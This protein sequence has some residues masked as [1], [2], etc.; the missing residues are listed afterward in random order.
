MRVGWA[1]LVEA[2]NDEAYYYLYNV[3]PDLSFIDHPP[4]T[5]WVMQAGLFLRGGLVDPLSLRLGFL[6]LFAGS[7]WAIFRVTARWYGEWAGFH[8]A[9][10]LNL[11][12]YYT[13]AAGAF[14]LP[15]GPFLFF[16]LLTIGALADALVAQTG[17]S[18]RQWCW[19]GLAWSGMLLSKYHAI[20]MPAG[21]LLYIALTPGTRRLLRTP[22]PYLA[23]AIGLLAFTPV[24]IW[25]VR[26]DWA[27]FAFQGGRALKWRFE[28]QG[29]IV[30]LL[31]TALMLSPWVWWG[32]VR[33][34]ADR[35]RGKRENIDR[36][37]LCLALV[38]MVFFLVLS[39]GR[40]VLAHWPLVGFIPLFCYI[41]QR[42]A[43]LAEAMP[44]RM[45]WNVG[46]MAGVLLLLA[47]A[48][49][50]QAKFGLAPL[51]SGDPCRQFSG[52]T[53]VADELQSRGLLGAETAFLFTSN[54]DDSGQ[55]AFAVRAVKPVLCYNSGDA[56][57]FAIWS[58]P[59]DWLGQDGLLVSLD[60]NQ[61]EPV[62]Y[63]R[64]FKKIEL[65]AAFPM[66]RGGR[67]FRSVRVFRCTCQVEP[68]PFHYTARKP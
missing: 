66:T 13:A 33:S 23:T 25:N 54:W 63:E 49:L 57:G 26:H 12:A 14:A 24:L 60:D 17:A 21:A 44:S 46:A 2:G 6:L 5:F 36:L 7:T 55:L 20:L 30:V 11:S 48:V 1:S 67:P 58:R 61:W 62:I 42:W 22:G 37:L 19:V 35:V 52:W 4:M 27:S 56:R 34:V 38:P 40:P 16:T 15:D 3:Y 51:Q 64:Y 8:A 32:M 50:V 18:T 31:A 47:S 59:E 53:S 28:F 45:R 9:L 65:V 43:V 10:A 68:Y 41:G 29:P 39:L